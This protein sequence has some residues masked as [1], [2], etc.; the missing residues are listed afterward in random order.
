VTRLDDVKALA[1]EINKK[2]GNEMVV[3]ASEVSDA[4]PRRTSGSLGLDLIL[5]GGWPANQ[6]SEVIG[7]ECLAPGTKVLC[8]DLTW[9][10]IEHLSVGDEIIGFDEDPRGRGKG[11][12]SKY[13]RSIV[14]SL[15]RATLPTYE[16]VTQYG[17]T[18]ASAGHMWLAAT[19]RRR[20]GSQRGWLRSDDLMPGDRI[21]SVGPTWP[22]L[23]SWE[24]G[25]LAGFWDG[26]GWIS[27]PHGTN[28]NSRAGINQAQGDLADYVEK[29]HV[30]A[31]FPLH[32][33]ESRR[34]KNKPHWKQQWK[35][36]FH[37]RYEDMRF[38]G[39][40]RPQR[41]L[42]KSHLLWE[43]VSTKQVHGNNAVVE[44]VRYVG[45]REVV[46]IGTSTKTLIADGLLSHN[47]SGKTS[48]VLKTIAANQKRDEDF[49]TVWIAAEK[50][51]S[52]WAETCGVDLS[53]V[54][55]VETNDMETAYDTA[56][57]FADS[58]EI[59]CIVIDSLPALVPSAEDEKNMA[60]STVG[61]GALLTGKFF[62]KVGA[63]TKRSLVE[64]E[65]PVLGIVIN[66][67]RQ[68]IGVMYGDP[69]TTPGGVGKNYAYF[70]RAEVRRGDWIEIGSGSDKERIGQT[71][72]I[73]TIKN[74]TAPAQR[75]AFVDFYFDEGGDCAPGHYDFAKEV[76]ALAVM[77]DI[78][79][80]RGAFYEYNGQKWRG[81]HAMLDAIRADVGLYES[82]V[83]EVSDVH[84]IAAR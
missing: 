35:Y 51:V 81:Q 29:M 16:I 53:R 3:L 9:Q 14:T 27:G 82:L 23:D 41:L 68:K 74:K 71:I 34:P 18:F 10:N 60:D 12:A 32:R 65:R 67:W 13:R 62:R 20:N 1:A 77:E 33:S 24:A 25:Y 40:V 66:Q 15:G 50:W 57:R 56:I 58:K 6:W 28:G 76:V 55:V 2:I 73:R 78:I 64:E 44:S 38:V 22:T 30:E 43:G 7:D 21:A 49:I 84:Q 52:E 26:E 48:V 54:F 11:N 72:Q 46:T 45:E 70:V 79:E 17:T 59:D 61:R 69:R 83:K 42:P 63:A 37:G 80:R 8:A 39:S 47:S 36:Q 19:T 5:G 75:V 31:G 4:V